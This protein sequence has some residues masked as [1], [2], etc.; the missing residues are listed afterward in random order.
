MNKTSDTKDCT[1]TVIPPPHI[2]SL[3]HTHTQGIILQH[4]IMP[5]C[6]G[7][8]RSVFQIPCWGPRLIASSATAHVELRF[9]CL[10]AM[11]LQD[12][13]TGLKGTEFQLWTERVMA[14]GVSGSVARRGQRGTESTCCDKEDDEMIT[15]TLYLHVSKQVTC[16][17]TSSLMQ[18]SEWGLVPGV[19]QKVYWFI[20]PLHVPSLWVGDCESEAYV[21]VRVVCCV[22]VWA[23]QAALPVIFPVPRSAHWCIPPTCHQFWWITPDDIFTFRR[24]KHHSFLSA[25]VFAVSSCHNTDLWQHFGKS[26]DLQRTTQGRGAEDFYSLFY[27]RPS[28]TCIYLHQGRG[29]RRLFHSHHSSFWHLCCWTVSRSVAPRAARPVAYR[30]WRKTRRKS[31][32]Q[33]SP[34]SKFWRNCTW[35]KDQT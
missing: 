34:S 2:L 13:V 15:S 33:K 29:W 10:V 23:G 9:N 5:P 24:V 28:K 6:R 11:S 21:W 12:S 17:Q 31:W 27:A 30:Q 25:P 3:H 1:M 16:K 20:V 26:F 32:W 4:D 18:I 8:W 7:T 22:C 19:W 14:C 35:K